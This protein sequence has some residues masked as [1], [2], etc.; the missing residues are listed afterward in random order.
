MAD[1]GACRW[2]GALRH[3]ART[4]LDGQSDW[5]TMHKVRID[6]LTPGR[7]YYYRTFSREITEYGAYHKEFG[8]SALTPVSSFTLPENGTKDLLPTSGCSMEQPYF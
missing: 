3:G 1:F 8:D 5:G 7:K 6:S 4:L 2:C